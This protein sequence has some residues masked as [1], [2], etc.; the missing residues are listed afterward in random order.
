VQLG[1]SEDQE[2]LRRFVRQFL[3]E[4][5]SES[6]V[7]ALMET[8]LGYDDAVWRQMA[9]QLG[10]Q[11][12]AID[13]RHGGGGFSF[14][15]LV[16]VLEEMGGALLC[17][18][19][20]STVVLAA[21]ALSHSGD[22]A[23]CEELLPAIV[24]G[25]CVATLAFE[26]GG[27]GFDVATFG[28]TAV[29]GGADWRLNGEKTY[30]LDGHAA[31]VVL[32]VAQT[33][34]GPGLFRCAGDADGLQRELLPTLDLTRKQARLTLSDTPAVPVG[35]PGSAATVLGRV[36]DLASVALAAEQVGGA[37]R[38]LD[39]AVGYSKER[40]Q[41]GRPI[42]SFQAIKHRCADMLLDTETA[43][44][45]AYYAGWC[46][47]TGDDDLPVAASMAQAHC[48]DA[49]FR[50]AAENIQI[51]GGI[52]FT[53]EHPAHLYFKRAKSSQLM[54]GGPTHHRAR[55]ADLVGL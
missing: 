31:D 13:E 12:I 52:G 45:A 35:A 24:S 47:A 15:E 26:E 19:Y 54:F 10:L 32:V 38:C 3:E 18:P 46:A 51:H 9:T 36:L 23:A 4:K 14:R 22:E 2:E 20:L 7:R 33:P 21:G 29:A 41:F 37:Q 27:R 17:A 40:M 16:L 30:V 34:D 11:G 49:Y 1:Y 50:A 48:S 28:T 39:M 6:A 8:E 5:S 55:L 25:E 42:G 43:R 44:S 53:W